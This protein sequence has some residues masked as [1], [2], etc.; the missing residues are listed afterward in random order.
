MDLNSDLADKLDFEPGRKFQEEIC[1]FFGKSVHH[2]SSSPS[3]SFFLLVNFRRYT[4]RLTEDSVSQVLQACLGGSAACFHVTFLSD[5]HFRFSI[6]CKAV[7]FRIYNLR[8]VIG[9]CFD[10]YF[11]LWSNGAPNWER[12]KF[13]WELEQEKEWTFVQR[14]RPPRNRR[15]NVLGKRVRFADKL[16]H[17][18]PVLKHQPKQEFIRFGDFSVPI[19][20]SDVFASLKKDLNIQMSDPSSTPCSSSPTQDSNFQKSNTTMCAKCLSPGHWARNCKFSW[21]CRTCFRY[22]HRAR[23]CLTKTKPR[24]FWAPKN[25][26]RDEFVSGPSKSEVDEDTDDITHLDSCAKIS[27]DPNL[28]RDSSPSPKLQ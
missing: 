4:F 16:V 24:L 15:A 3:G 21:H 2:P 14:S 23:W 17:D 9:S 22:G 12:E 11:H 18:S 5:R 10:V 13:L 28:P 19:P 1:R 25:V 7:G 8:H 20:V 26:T 27:E 6:S